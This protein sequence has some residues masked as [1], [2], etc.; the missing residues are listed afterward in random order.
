MAKELEELLLTNMEDVVMAAALQVTDGGGSM[1][2][3]VCLAF[4]VG[5][6]LRLTWRCLASSLVSFL[7]RVSAGT[8]KDKSARA[9]CQREEEDLKYKSWLIE[10]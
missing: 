4:S 9:L 6:G 1:T 7:S 5:L 2:K 3:C 10:G 8:S